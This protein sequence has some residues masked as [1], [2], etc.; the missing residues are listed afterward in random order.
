[1]FSISI[2]ITCRNEEKFIGSC[3]DSLVSQEA[4]KENL[5][6]LV[7]DGKSEDKT[8]DIVKKYQ[9]KY[10]VKLIDNPYKVT[11]KGM[12][13]GIKK[14][15][16]DIVI[17]INSHSVLDKVF[18]KNIVYSLEKHP[19]ADAI[20]GRLEAITEGNSLLS[21]TIS[22]CVDS[23]FGSGGVR[24][25]QRKKEGFVKDTLPY[26]AYRRNVFEKIGYMDENL[27]RGQDA[28]LN[29]RLIKRGGKIYF[30]PKI[31]S[32]LH[33]RPYL[34]KFIK[35]QFQYGYFKVKI[36]QKLG[37][38]L[39]GRQIIPAIFV[40]SLI[41]STVLFLFKNIFGLF[42]LFI[43]LL[44]LLTDIIFSIH[45]CLKRGVKYLLPSIIIFLLFHLSYGLGFIK[46]A[47]DFLVFRK[48]IKKDIGITR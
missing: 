29:L 34:T 21:K 23:V 41:L 31:K 9:E 48:G 14:S 43:F 39:I 42:F 8:T 25:R 46:G 16:G 10:P 44:Y 7:V 15:S 28:E 33:T 35:Q 13:I 32:Y 27:L 6:I 26:C 2:I 17:L 24:Y 4:Y 12:N 11:P 1:M 38:R 3:L 36:G 5:E 45:I 20:G 37:A 30:N 19:E 18:L 22:C 47:I 40:F